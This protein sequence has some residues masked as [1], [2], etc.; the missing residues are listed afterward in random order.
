MEQQSL[1]R[2]AIRR[3]MSFV[4]ACFVCMCPC[5]CVCVHVC[6]CVCVTLQ[7]D[8]CYRVQ[9][10]RNC[11]VVTVIDYICMHV[12]MRQ[13]KERGWTERE[14]ERASAYF[15]FVL[16]HRRNRH[17]VGKNEKSHWWSR[18][19][20]KRK[21]RATH[22]EGCCDNDYSLYGQTAR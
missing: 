7:F 1:A 15:F 13:E 20:K 21:E 19:R 22:R 8:S 2:H 14:R 10:N 12:Y 9:P 18:H 17:G 4:C 5:L 11:T 3:Y 16:R 6:R